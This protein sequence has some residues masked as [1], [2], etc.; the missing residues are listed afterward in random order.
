MVKRP[1]KQRKDKPTMVKVADVAGVSTFTVSAVVNGS[2]WVSDELRGR[3][4]AAIRQTG[5]RPS[6]LAQSLRTGQSK[7]IGLVVGDI[8]NPFYTDI[9]SRLQPTLMSAGYA[10]I[11][12]SH[13]RSIA[14]QD[15]ELHLLAS[16]N[17][18]GLILAP[19]GDDEPLRVALD[20]IEAPVV[21]IDRTVEGYDCDAVLLDNRRAVSDV[22]EQLAKLGH[23]RIGFVAG[24]SNSY[25][26][27]ERIAAFR[28]MQSDL[29]L[30]ADPELILQGNFLTEDA[31]DAAQA[32]L[33]LPERP[34]A[35]LAANNKSVIGVMRALSREGLKC[36]EDVSVAVIDDFAWADAF[37]PTLTAIAQPLDEI[38]DIA[39]KLLFERI[40]GDVK[41]AGRQKV[42]SGKL[43]VRE[44]TITP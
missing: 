3:V 15:E 6:V 23:R 10:T 16:R 37:H 7:T 29:S 42:L 19:I 12:C 30:D 43:H 11:L 35:I 28:Q 2:T 18:D 26:G 20:R 22:M 8:T 31:I 24:A 41:G 5:Y 39:A 36:P 40:N 14:Q 33:S 4:E 32:L 25:T 1:R 9:V 27:R 38:A 17:V 21:L 34:T 13:V 44:S